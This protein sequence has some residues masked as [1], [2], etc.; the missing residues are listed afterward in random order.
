[1][2]LASHLLA[3]HH[4]D[5][6]TFRS[7]AFGRRLGRWS[8]TTQLSETSK[9]RCGYVRSHRLL[10]NIVPSRWWKIRLVALSPGSLK[11][12]HHM[13]EFMI[14]N[15]GSTRPERKTFSP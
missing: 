10:T 1:L 9:S 4:N 6:V 3:N 5:G 12:S 11:V 2:A 14:W 7:E 8:T 15:L 13:E